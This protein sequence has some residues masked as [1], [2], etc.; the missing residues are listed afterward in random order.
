MER[1]F[2]R[3][4]G[5]LAGL[6][7]GIFGSIVLMALVSVVYTGDPLGGNVETPEQIYFF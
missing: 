3:N 4:K 1:Y 7:V 2:A 5:K 6:A